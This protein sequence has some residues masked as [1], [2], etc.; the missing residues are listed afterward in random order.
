MKENATKLLK[1]STMFC[2]ALILCFCVPQMQAKADVAED[3]AS[4]V[5]NIRQTDAT[6]N[7]VGFT[8]DAVAGDRVSYITY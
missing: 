7:S 6:A 4:K 3:P 8:W 2:M 1:V 5:V